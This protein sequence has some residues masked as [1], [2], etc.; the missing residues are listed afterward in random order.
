MRGRGFAPVTFKGQGADIGLVREAERKADY[1]VTGFIIDRIKPRARA[2]PLILRSNQR[3]ADADG[4]PIIFAMLFE[5]YV[6]IQRDSGARITA[7]AR[8]PD[9]QLSASV[10]R[11]WL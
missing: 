11:Y 3:V 5:L 1:L 2:E 9:A 8:A 10:L 4:K 6:V 7:V